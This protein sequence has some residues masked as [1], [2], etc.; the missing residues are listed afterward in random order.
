MTTR[1]RLGR[2]ARSLTG[3]AQ[4]K[5]LR[6]EVGGLSNSMSD[7]NAPLDVAAHLAAIVAFS[8]DVIVSKTLQGIITSWNPTAERIFGYRA[9]E[10]I[11]K[12]IRLIIPP[13]RWAEE[14]EVLARIGRGE[15]VE[16][17]E[18]VRRAKDGRLLNMS[19]TVSPIKDRSG[20]IIG[21][22][23]VA[24]DITERKLAEQ[25]RERLLASEK[26]SRAQAEEASRL[27]DEFL[28]LV[29]HELRT[30]LNAIMGWAS[31]LRMRKLDE[32]TAHAI[33]TIQ[34]NAQT[35]AQLIADLLD[36][37][38][39][40][41]GQMRLNIRPVEIATVLD[42][43]L[44]AVRPS[45]SA[46]SIDLQTLIDPA[47]GPITAD[48][49]RLQQI[50]WNLLSNAIKF[51]PKGGQVQVR[52]KRADSHLEVI[53]SDTGKGIDRKLLPFVFDRFRQGDSSTTREHV[54]LGLGLAIVRHLVELHGGAVRASSEGEGKGA[55]FVVELPT[56]VLARLPE[57]DKRAR[58]DP[59]VGE[60][61]QGPMPS[62]AG[63]RI[64]L[65]DDEPDAREVV[66][67]ILGA[68]GAEVASAAS[69]RAALEM[70]RE[71]NPDVLVS[72]IG[73]PGEDG[74]ELIRKVRALPPEGGGRVPAIALTAFARTQDRLKVIS[75]GYQMHVPKPVEPVE[76]ATVVAS[77]IRRL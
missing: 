5:A 69:A 36:V 13:D 52:V 40:V 23:K 61:I 14:D 26:H 58:I 8:D 42:A 29:S 6:L 9:A 65:V 73:M 60:A 62:L 24:R 48:P 45:A 18:T 43:A 34:R 2:R 50:F 16:H 15:R 70:V 10:A 30:P 67:A 27:K 76:L 54:G 17:F 74:Y 55:E 71:L 33:E 12:H 4:A 31:L 3:A 57:P 39:I 47:A 21:A 75:A 32:Q 7:F 64:L 37:S 1:A 35:Q 72:D 19:L 77:L 25:E 49:D 66:A 53:V 38:R 56:S 59:I 41:S 46:K 20:R 11:G 68:A 28:A 22:S 63:L 44:E 51:T